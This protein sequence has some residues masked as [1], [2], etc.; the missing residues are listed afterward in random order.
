MKGTY[1]IHLDS[2]KIQEARF[3]LI[4][5]DPARIP[6]IASQISDNHKELEWSREFRSYLS[7][8]Q[9]TPI[10]ILSHGIGGPSTAIV[11]EEI[12]MI[13]IQT[14]I[15]I[16]TTG[17]IQDNIKLGDV[18]I[19]SASVRLDG[20]TVQYVPI[21]YPA[22]A[23]PEIVMSLASSAEDLG[24]PFHVGITASTDAFYPGQ[25]RYDSCLKYVQKKLQGSQEEWKMF[26]VLNYEMESST[27]FTLGNLFKMRTGCVTGVVDNRNRG[28]SIEENIKQKAVENAI[29]TAVLTIKEKLIKPGI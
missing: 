12:G 22:S 2:E 4:T 7:I 26:N 8:Y 16:G 14:V 29:K 13:G 5:G 6:E 18:I 20:T 10:L 17:A 3:A 27:V 9:S 21:E 11:M 25:E 23:T 24:I 15:R 19:S 28:E 1:H